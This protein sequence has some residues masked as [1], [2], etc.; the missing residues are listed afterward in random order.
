M[1]IYK[2]NLVEMMLQEA[3]VNDTYARESGTHSVL[4]VDY[5]S[6]ENMTLL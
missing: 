3:S 2:K 1:M 4:T 5:D 6:K